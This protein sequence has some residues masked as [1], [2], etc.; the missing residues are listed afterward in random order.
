MINSGN[1]LTYKISG[2]QNIKDV[3][4]YP[5]TVRVLKGNTEIQKGTANYKVTKKNIGDSDLYV[6]P[7]TD[8][9]YTGSALYPEFLVAY[10]GIILDEDDYEAVYSNNTNVGTATITLVAKGDGNYE[11]TREI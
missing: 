9:Y 11:G 2:D 3:G 8:Q 10:S 1:E 5:I 6:R 7:M 4:T